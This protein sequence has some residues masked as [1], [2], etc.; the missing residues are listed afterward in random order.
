VLYLILKAAISGVIIV[1][2][3]LAWPGA[4]PAAAAPP[5]WRVYADCAAAYLAN[6][7]IAD[8]DRPAAMTAQISDVAKDYEAAARARYR[9]ATGAGRAV[10]TR[11]ER[12]ARAF[13]GQPREAVEKIID[14]CPQ[15]GG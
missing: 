1:A 5:G 15:V 8:P 11:I 7:R 6:A 14:A 3:S 10:R 4:D 13:Y 12:Q 2:S 9:P